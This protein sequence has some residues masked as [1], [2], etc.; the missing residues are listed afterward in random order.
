MQLINIIGTALALTSATAMAKPLVTIADVKLRGVHFMDHVKF[1]GATDSALE[2]RGG[3]GSSTTT[4]TTTS[5]TS[6]SSTSTVSSSSS[7]TSV[8]P[9]STVTSTS[10]SSSSTTAS[11]TTSSAAPAYTNYS[12]K[13]VYNGGPIIPNVNVIPLWW[14]SSVSY[15]SQLP[16]FYAGI[17]NSTYWDM[18]KQYSISSTSIIGRGTVGTPIT[19]NGY[20]TATTIDDTNDIVPYLRSLVQAGT[21]SPTINTYYPIHFPAGVT[22]TLTGYKSCSYFCAY[23]STIDI[24]DISSTQYLYYGVMPDQGGSCLGG[25]G[26]SL[27]TFSNLCSVS[28]HE[29][30]EATTD[31][32]IGVVTGSTVAAPAAWY[33]SIDGSSGG[34]IGDICNAQQGTVV[35]GNGITYT[36]QKE[37][38]NKAAACA[39]V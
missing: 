7:T 28:S 36:V 5:A 20:P 10:S 38:S 19:L 32:A 35:G 12:G 23:H 26:S 9:S 8:T 3:G 33:D 39:L 22:I 18:L 37:W 27:S 15:T 11:S 4:T 34:E 6:A 13:L 17:V 14:G 25:C 29:I 2:R 21:I 1:V 24:S 30:V 16:G 31:P